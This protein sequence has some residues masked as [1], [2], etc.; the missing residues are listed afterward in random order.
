[1]DKIDEELSKNTSD[2]FTPE[3]LA[4]H[5]LVSDELKKVDVGQLM[6]SIDLDEEPNPNIYNR[7]AY[8]FELLLTIY[9]EM[10]F[11]W[12]KL[13]HLMDNEQKGIETDFKPDLS[14]LSLDDLENPFK[15]KFEIIGYNLHINEITDM[16]YYEN[17]RVKSYCRTALRDLQSDFGFF[18]L[19]KNNIDPEKRYHFVM[20]GG[21]KGE[22]N[23]RNIYML[24]KINNVGYKINF[25]HTL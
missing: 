17:L 12:F 19:N 24:I 1:M 21:F 25:T 14:K 22:K 16:D 10:V 15:E 3:S 8:E 11:G 6:A 9:M 20:N 7:E 18:N 4:W 5:L 2:V 13:L 23:L